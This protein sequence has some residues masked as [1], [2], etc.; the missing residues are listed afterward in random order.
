[1]DKNAASLACAD[2]LSDVSEPEE[3]FDDQIHSLKQQL[4]QLEAKTHPEYLKVKRKVD[5]WLAEEKQRVHV[6]HEHR[7]ETISREYKKE[8]ASCD[9]DCA[10]EKRRTQE[11]LVSLCEELK[12]RLEHDKKNIELTPSGDVLDFKPAV[13]RKLRRRGGTDLPT[14]GYSNFM[15]WGDLLLCG[16]NWPLGGSSNACKSSTPELISNS[17]VKSPA[18]NA[19]SDF[20]Q[21]NTMAPT[22]D[23]EYTDSTKP[24]RNG[25]TG[26]T[27]TGLQDG[28]V[29]VTSSSLKSNLFG[30][31]GVNLFDGS[32]LSHLLASINSV[33]TN[34]CG[35]NNYLSVNTAS[36]SFLGGGCSFLNGPPPGSAAAAAV[37]AAGLAIPSVLTSTS[38]NNLVAALG[39]VAT[40]LTGG[41]QPSAKKRRQQNAVPTAQLNLLLPEN[42]IYSDLTVIHRAC[43]KAAS[44]SGSQPSGGGRK[45]SQ[46]GSTT[47]PGSSAT[48]GLPSHSLGQSSHAGSSTGSATSSRG[49][50]DPGTPNSNQPGSDSL[51][52]PIHYSGDCIPLGRSVN[53]SNG[54]SSPAPAPIGPSVW[55]DDGRLYCGQKCFQYGATVILEGRDGAN[56]RCTGTIAAVGAQDVAIR[57]SSDHGICRITVQQLKQ[58]R[59]VLHP[60][61]PS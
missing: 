36:N 42:D 8:V 29:T 23:S 16:T 37:A 13:T 28:N 57:R 61:K 48:P 17:E 38:P 44:A 41:I 35:L 18:T 39:P 12:R 60:G 30:S 51:G 24:V 20:P 47:T 33:G 55:I 21:D 26:A 58:G 19:G 50:L 40:G 9:R 46:H 49:Q 3:S 54:P 2:G 5:A 25:A 32:L 6:L 56:Q 4:K 22:N 31:L 43:A 1:M 11:Y 52:S 53:Q 7:L 14:A 59:Y 45:H 15:Y 10:L 34:T 27:D